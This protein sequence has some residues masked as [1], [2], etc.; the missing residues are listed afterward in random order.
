MQYY[1][2]ST[3]TQHKVLHLVMLHT[4]IVGKLHQFKGCDITSIY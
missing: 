2:V 1:T 3:H 4:E